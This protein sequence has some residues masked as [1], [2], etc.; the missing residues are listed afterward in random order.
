MNTILNDVVFT[1]R[2]LRRSPGYALTILLSL[3]IGIGLNTIVFSVINATLLNPL[4]Y[5]AQDRI[6]VIWGKNFQQPSKRLLNSSGDYLDLKRS[7]RTFEHLAAYD[8]EG[9]NLSG[10]GEPEWVQGAQVSANF[11]SVLGE[12]VVQGR[13]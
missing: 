1:I 7:N 2:V 4:P 12:K 10:G 11:F 3:A 8:N 9:F 5:D 6:V 13:T